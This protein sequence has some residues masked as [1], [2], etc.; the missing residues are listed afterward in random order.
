MFQREV[1]A[2]TLVVGHGLDNDLR[3]LKIVHPRSAKA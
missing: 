1:D 2:E 3:A